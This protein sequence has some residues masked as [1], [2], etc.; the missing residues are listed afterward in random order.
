MKWKRRGAFAEKR[1]LVLILLV[2]VVV[3]VLS[4]SGR[5]RAGAFAEKRLLLLVIVLPVTMAG[6]SITS[7]TSTVGMPLLL[8][9]LILVLGHGSYR[10]YYSTSNIDGT[11]ELVLLRSLL[12]HQYTVT[13]TTDLLELFTLGLL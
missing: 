12:L 5:G 8:P 1:L 7:I 11:V 6:N 4:I 13:I 2:V 9:S 10:C 3:L